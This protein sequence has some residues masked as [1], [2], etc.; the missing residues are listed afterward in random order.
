[1]EHKLYRVKKRSNKKSN[2]VDDRI[3]LPAGWN[4]IYIPNYS[5]LSSKNFEVIRKSHLARLPEDFS[6]M[7][8]CQERNVDNCLRKDN[9][10]GIEVELG[11][12]IL[13]STSRKMGEGAD[14]IVR[15][16]IAKINGVKKDVAVKIMNVNKK[17]GRKYNL[18]LNDFETELEYSILMGKAGIAPQVYG[19]FFLEMPNLYK[20]IIIMEK[21]DGDLGRLLFDLVR[22]EKYSNQLSRKFQT[23]LV[24]IVDRCAYIMNFQIQET[25]IICNDIKPGN[26]VY[27]MEPNGKILVKMIDFGE[28]FCELNSISNADRYLIYTILLCGMSIGMQRNPFPNRNPNFKKQ[29]QQIIQKTFLKH[30]GEPRSYLKPET[31]ETLQQPQYKE[32]VLTTIYYWLNNPRILVVKQLA[33]LNNL[34]KFFLDGFGQLTK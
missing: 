12:I 23:Q 18:N 25:G 3:P 29:Y 17:G 26:F 1:M 10:W 5:D 14:G 13:L 8:Q 27:R 7:R 15:E 11:S 19:S 31:V 32:M 6:F 24:E 20:C 2:A 4:P 28:R 9:A 34:E 21:F 30:S 22:N 33:T 16:G